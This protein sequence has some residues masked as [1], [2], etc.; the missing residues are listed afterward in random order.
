MSSKVWFGNRAKQAWIPAPQAGLEWS[1]IKR[2]NLI[3]LENGG[4]YVDDSRASHRE[5]TPEWAGTPA[6]LRTIK[7]FENGVWGPGPY[8]LVDPYVA[9][10][11]MLSP[12]WAA[13][14]IIAD[15][16]WPE[17]GPG[18]GVAASLATGPLGQPT[19]AITYTPTVLH[20]GA[21]PTRRFTILIPPGHKL[22]F[23]AHGTRTGSGVIA[24]RGTTAAGGVTN[25]TAI[26]LDPTG[27]TVFSSTTLFPYSSGFRVVDIFLARSTVTTSTVTLS[28][29]RARLLREDS[30]IA[31]SGTPFASG[32][33]AADLS[34]SGSLREVPEFIG[35]RGNPATRRK[36]LSVKLVEQW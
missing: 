10:I 17:I 30:F 25:A 24:L 28:S 19:R 11:N 20:N 13:P 36:R 26:P 27:N 21:L 23:G 34:F 31:T 5:S 18:A 29:I 9:D 12:W 33:G 14:G 2:S 3:S 8:W 7:E 22:A 1:L 6:E 4:V 35:H 16:D 32:E 15:G